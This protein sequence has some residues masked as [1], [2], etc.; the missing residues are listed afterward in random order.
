MVAIEGEQLRWER[1]N[2]RPIDHAMSIKP[3][4]IGLKRDR[5]DKKQNE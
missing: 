3:P 1:E 5:S 2:G 4:R